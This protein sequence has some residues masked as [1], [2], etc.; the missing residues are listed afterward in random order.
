MHQNRESHGVPGLLSG[1]VSHRTVR[2]DSSQEYYLYLPRHVDQNSRLFVSVHGISRNALEHAELFAPFAERYGVVIVAPLFPA[3]KF[4]GYQRIFANNQG[5]RADHVLDRIV[6]EV[7]ELTG[8]LSERAYLFGYSGGAQFVHRYT[9]AYPDRVAKVVIGAAG[10][11]T[12]PD[13]AR[14]Y[15]FGIKP[16]PNFPGIDPDPDR[17]LRIPAYVLVGERDVREDRTLNQSGRVEYF[18]G[19]TRLE[20]GKRWIEEMTQ[21]ARARGLNTDY[22]FFTIPRSRHS[23]RQCMKRGEMG[24]LVFRLL[25]GDLS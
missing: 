4:H 16:N 15:P 19:E 10:W 12:F 18:E 7:R 3:S 13:P 2:S 25:F 9:M 23:F 24:N 8:I 1:T 11:Y 14:L 22:G 6:E 21:A 17:F 5:E 20:R